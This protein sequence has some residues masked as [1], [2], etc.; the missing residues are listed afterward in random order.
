MHNVGNF[1]M[2]NIF[3]VDYFVLLIDIIYFSFPFPPFKIRIALFCNVCNFLIKVELGQKIF[4][5]N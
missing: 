4:T 2:I 3:N 1:E 5:C